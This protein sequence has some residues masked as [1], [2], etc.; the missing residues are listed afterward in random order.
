[1]R[2]AAKA[3]RRYRKILCIWNRVRVHAADR[4]MCQSKYAW[5]RLVEK[6]PCRR[7]FF[8]QLVTSL[9]PSRDRELS[10]SF[11]ITPAVTLRAKALRPFGDGY[12]LWNALRS[13]TF[14]FRCRVTRRHLC[15]WRGR[16]WM[17][18]TARPPSAAVVQVK[19]LTCSWSMLPGLSDSPIMPLA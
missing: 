15:V 9:Y 16:H 19:R 1:M 6:S 3:T 12:P 17:I 5:H 2:Q 14:K 11:H 13:T 8:I 4:A 18:T 7:K 10:Q